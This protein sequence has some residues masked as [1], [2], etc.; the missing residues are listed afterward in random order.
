MNLHSTPRKRFEARNRQESSD[1]TKDRAIAPLRS[2]FQTSRIPSAYESQAA[3]WKIGFQKASNESYRAQNVGIEAPLVSELCSSIGSS[4]FPP[5]EVVQKLLRN[6]NIID[7]EYLCEQLDEKLQDV[8]WQVQA[9]AL[10]VIDALIKSKERAFYERYYARRIHLVLVLKQSR[11]DMLRVH[12]ALRLALERLETE[13]DDESIEQTQLERELQEDDCDS[14]LQEPTEEVQRSV[15]A[16]QLGWSPAASVVGG[17]SFLAMTDERSKQLC[18]DTNSQNGPSATENRGS[19]AEREPKSPCA[20]SFLTETT[21]KSPDV[22]DTLALPNITKN[23]SPKESNDPFA[24][25]DDIVNSEQIIDTE[26]KDED[27][28]TVHG[29]QTPLFAGTELDD[30]SREV[31]LEAEVPPGPIGLVLDD[32]ILEMAVI[33][34]FISL[35]SGAKGMLELHPALCPG[36]KLVFINSIDVQEKSLDE[37]GQ[38]LAQLATTPKVFR[39]RKYIVHGRTANPATM[40]VPYVPPPFSLADA[41]STEND[42]SR[43]G[44]SHLTRLYSYQDELE[45][46]EGTVDELMSSELLSRDVRNRLAQIHGIVEKILTEKVDSVIFGPDTSAKLDTI[47]A[48]RSNLVKKADDLIQRIQNKIAEIDQERTCAPSMQN[49]SDI[50]NLEDVGHALMPETQ[51]DSLHSILGQAPSPCRDNASAFSFLACESTDATDDQS[52]MQSTSPT[53]FNF[54]CSRN[55]DT[56]EQASSAFSFITN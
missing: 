5:R 24:A 42:E 20:F 27:D 6:L 32:T 11:K 9:K 46:V 7:H 17:P 13:G 55:D 34:R 49:A 22:F 21:K 23:N 40:A 18:I 56:T 19:E 4:S 50:Y 41:D 28:N 47:R 53:A 3:R 25:F 52:M 26:E 29:D 37:I 39:F 35:P 30:V 44:D 15:C 31:I 14:K 10:S 51:R 38:I 1:I 12:N 16:S 54:M 33:A 2:P 48:V 43:D 45:A 36:C 8:I